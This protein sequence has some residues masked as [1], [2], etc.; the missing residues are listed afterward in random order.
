MDCC[1]V[2][3]MDGV[4]AGSGWVEMIGV[5]S[6]F[7]GDSVSGLNGFGLEMSIVTSMSYIVL[8]QS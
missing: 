6:T 7:G 8:I 3:D 5:A 1:S 2:A 4:R